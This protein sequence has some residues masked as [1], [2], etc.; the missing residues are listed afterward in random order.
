MSAYEEARRAKIARNMQMMEEMGL[1]ASATALK[2]R[3]N[4]AKPKPIKR[5]KTVDDD[6]AAPRRSS[7][8]LQGKEAVLP[9]DLQA[10]L[11]RELRAHLSE[12]L[13]AN[14]ASFPTDADSAAL[15]QL[16]GRD[17]A[18]RKPV[19]E[20]PQE[21]AKYTLH[22]FD[23]E[24][25]TPSRIYAIACHPSLAKDHIL[26]AIADVDGNVAL[27]SVPLDRDS[28]DD[29]T[30]VTWRP[31]KQAISSI[32]FEADTLLTSAFDGSIQQYDLVTQ[33]RT[34]VFHTDVALTYVDISEPNA[35]LT[36]D[37]AGH[38][39]SIDRRARGKPTSW[40]LH[41]KKINTVHRQPGSTHSFATA[42]LDR[43]VC[44]WDARQPSTP[45]VT[46]P[47]HR[48]I[49]CAYFSPNGEWL[50]T[51]GQDD[52]VHLY[53]MPATSDK[54]TT[55]FVHN[56]QTGRW[57]TKFHAHWDPKCSATPRY[58]LGS[59]QQPRC[60]EIFG[61][62]TKQPLQRLDDDLCRSVFSMNTFH[63]SIDVIVSGNSSGRAMV[64]RA[65]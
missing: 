57:L 56:N 44:L 12:E 37:E 14:E 15:G 7:R 6:V 42:S 3:V 34:D 8:R 46:L 19:V 39:F 47:H 5:K 23:V 30:I 54:P 45:L 36:C 52:Y 63:P 13:V 4:A 18:E 60:I 26:S 51:V 2:Q 41:E 20:A 17:G 31:H 38:V 24:K 32:H 22:E 16:F 58:V 62:R 59:N 1:K 50:V 11:P 29:N 21:D 43:T 64:W 49:N 48:S 27:W 65:K 53:S 10:P 61:A 25:V 9:D 35:L 40:T 33:A 55:R 28:S